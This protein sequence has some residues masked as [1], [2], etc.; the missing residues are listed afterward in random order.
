MAEKQATEL[1]NTYIDQLWKY[2]KIRKIRDPFVVKE[3]LCPYALTDICLTKL[4][5][6]TAENVRLILYSKE[7]LEDLN[8]AGQT[9]SYV[10]RH[11]L[12]HELGH[13]VLG[14]HKNSK[15]MEALLSIY[16]QSAPDPKEW[17]K[18]G[19]ANP[20][21]QEL[22]ADIY[23]VWALSKLEKGFTVQQ[24]VSQFNTQ[25]LNQKD[26]EAIAANHSDHPLFRDRI[27]TMRK[28]E[29]QMLRA[30]SKVVPRKYF[31]DIAS[32]A[33]LDLW[34]DAPVIDIA[35]NAGIALGGITDFSYD[36]EK[37]DGFLYPPK[38]LK[39]ISNYHAGLSITRFRWDRHWQRHVDIQWSRHKY[40]TTV[41]GGSEEQLI[42]KFQVDYLT[43]APRMTW[44]SA[45]GG[46]KGSFQALRVGLIAGFGFNFRI[47]AGKISYT[48]YISDVP[49]PKSRFTLGPKAVVGVSLLKKT[50]LPKGANILFSYDPQWIRLDTPVKTCVISHN[51]ECTLQ[52]S[53]FRH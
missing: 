14:H 15:S 8:K 32:S 49:T 26:K 11:V 48:N 39:S 41:Q 10:D 29:A 9:A 40:G 21:A 37:T 7:F 50:F 31:S 53:I 6:G 33:Y 23:A 42:E 43:V 52:Y 45:T 27:E 19:A 17:R 34:P 12:L 46:K 51:L 4:P 22:E 20:M 30:Q 38:T 24:L 13:H 5:D 44:N 25:I 28:F 1:L 35:L 36:G 18:Y 3:A 2:S 47:P 16:K